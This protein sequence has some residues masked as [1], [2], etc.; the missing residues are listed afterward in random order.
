MKQETLMPDY[1]NSILNMVSSILGNYNVKDIHSTLPKLDLILEKKYKNIVL[2]VLDG[3]G[4]NVLK[5][6]SPNGIFMEHQV[7]SITT[8]YPSTTTAALTTYYSGKAPIETGWIAWSQY[9]KEYGRNINMLPYID[10]YTEEPLPRDEFDI[11]ELLKYK[12]VYE[13]IENASP[14]VTT[15]EIKP[16]HCEMKADKCIHIKD[17]KN[18]CSS[19]E[20]L[21]RNDEKKYIFAYFDSPD[22]INHKYGWDSKNTKEFILEAEKLFKNLTENLKNT[23]TLIIVSADHGHNN[24]LNTDNIYYALDID[25][26]KSCYIMPPSLESRF[27]SFWIKPDKKEYFEKTFKKM[28]DGEFLLYSKEDFLASHLMGYGKPHYKIDDFIGDYVAIAISYSLLHIHTYLSKKKE[29]KKSH[30]C[31]L[32]KNEMEVPFIVFDLK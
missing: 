12:T 1:K 31:G 13:Q 8:V 24:V 4:E 30:H 29:E 6:A 16:S 5:N 2:V 11:Y 15:Y 23:D 10:S 25:E 3:M 9:F 27:V 20:T 7:D 21:C 18:L 22:N 28:F 26:L 19:I 32:T 14:D 17:L